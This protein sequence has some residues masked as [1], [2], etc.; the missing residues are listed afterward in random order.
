MAMRE[1]SRG[2]IVKN[3]NK[4]GD[5]VYVKDNLGEMVKQVGVGVVKMKGSE[6][7]NNVVMEE[8]E[9]RRGEVKKDGQSSSMVMGV[10]INQL[11]SSQGSRK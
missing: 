9:E 7:N 5:G 1:E 4:D 11:N 6:M 2:Q 8:E 3:N 10:G